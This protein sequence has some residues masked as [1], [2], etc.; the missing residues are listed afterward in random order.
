MIIS[1]NAVCNPAHHHC[2]SFKVIR[3]Q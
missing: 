2:D 3:C 1:N